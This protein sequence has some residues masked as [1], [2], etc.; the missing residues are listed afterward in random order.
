MNS[1][2]KILI[3][4]GVVLIVV[5]GIFVLGIKIPWIGKLPGDVVIKRENFSFY[6]PVMT[7]ILLSLILSFL[8][9][10]LLRK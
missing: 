10:F 1:I 8:L 5:G 3:V 2:G 6:F 7:C 9:H 4:S